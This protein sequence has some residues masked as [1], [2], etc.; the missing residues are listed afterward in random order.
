[1]GNLLLG[2]RRGLHRFLVTPE[3]FDGGFGDRFSLGGVHGL[4]QDLQFF[5]GALASGGTAGDPD[6]H[7]LDAVD[8]FSDLQFAF[9]QLRF[10]LAGLLVERNDLAAEFIAIPADLSDFPAQAHQIRL[11]IFPRELCVGENGS[12]GLF[13]SREGQ[14]E[15]VDF[16][17]G[18]LLSRCGEIHPSEGRLDPVEDILA[19]GEIVHRYLMV[20]K[21]MID[22]IVRFGL[23]AAAE[24]VKS[25]FEI[26]ADL[27][28]SL[29]PVGQKSL[30]TDEGSLVAPR[31]VLRLKYAV[32][33]DEQCV[34]ALDSLGF[35]QGMRDLK[36]VADGKYEGGLDLQNFEDGQPEGHQSAD[37]WI[38]EDDQGGVSE[39]LR[40]EVGHSS[41]VP[42]PDRRFEPGRGQGREV[43]PG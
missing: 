31:I 8:E 43:V 12:E 39:L 13:R 2:D 35:F 3:P 9:L 19:Y 29:S 18:R 24:A 32:E 16:A 25:D 37:S 4:E 22:E 17:S 20:T 1:M 21:A 14:V 41:N 42:I 15:L 34:L 26:D 28:D 33:P 38:L 27:L 36:G 5:G 10:E 23:G 40:D 30:I 6:Q 7:E 11:G